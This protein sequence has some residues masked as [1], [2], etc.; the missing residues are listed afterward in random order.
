[1]EDTIGAYK[2]KWSV[3]ADTVAVATPVPIALNSASVSMVSLLVITSPAEFLYVIVEASVTH[4]CA[5]SSQYPIFKVSASAKVL[6]EVSEE[7]AVAI[8]SAK[9]KVIST[10]TGSG[11]VVMALLSESIALI[12]CAF[13]PTGFEFEVD[14]TLL[15]CFA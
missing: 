9:V 7:E 2:E 15:V 11:S 12:S 4:D 3:D 8:N 10:V 6:M 14:L 1:M 13:P 5:L